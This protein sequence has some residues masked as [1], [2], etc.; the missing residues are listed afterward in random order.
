[1]KPVLSSIFSIALLALLPAPAAHALSVARESPQ[2][3]FP[4]NYDGK[5]AEALSAVIT[6]AKFRYL[7]GLT[8]FWEPEWSTTLVYEGDTKSLHEFLTGLNGVEGMRV[9]L[10]ISADLS[11]ESGSAL[12]AGSWWLIYSHTSPDTVTVRINLAAET[13]KG[14][15]LE[16]L[17][18]KP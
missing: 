10:T 9:R 18:P 13:F 7:G 16:I 8:S 6:S 12:R 15:T 11:K 3:H 2:I 14:D 4:S 5:R 1:M 17:L